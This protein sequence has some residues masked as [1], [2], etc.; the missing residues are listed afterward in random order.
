MCKYEPI[1]FANVDRHC[2]GAPQA[3]MDIKDISM[4]SAVSPNYDS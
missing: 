3:H 2:L 1:T 4:M